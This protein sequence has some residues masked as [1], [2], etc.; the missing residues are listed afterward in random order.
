MDDANRRELVTRHRHDVKADFLRVQTT[1][2]HEDALL[3]S[4]GTLECLRPPEDVAMTGRQLV[5]STQFD[6]IHNCF[7]VTRM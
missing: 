6:Q 3:L 7:L 2:F 1:L 5:G 4:Y